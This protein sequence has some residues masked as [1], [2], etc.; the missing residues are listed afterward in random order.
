MW[1]LWFSVST[2]WHLKYS[3]ACLETQPKVR[4][5]LDLQLPNKS[6]LAHPLG[7]SMWLTMRGRVQ[8]P[9]AW[10]PSAGPSSVRLAHPSR[11]LRILASQTG[12]SGLRFALCPLWTN[13]T[14]E[15]CVCTDVCVC[16]SPHLA[17]FHGLSQHDY[18]VNLLVPHHLPEVIDSP[19]NR[20]C[21]GQDI[22]INTSCSMLAYSL[23][24]RK[25]MRSFLGSIITRPKHSNRTSD[26]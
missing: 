5:P 23:C 3:W 15:E 22:E 26:T 4:K 25:Q 2:K 13:G 8:P 6:C 12:H 9:A 7:L 10:Y 11:A 1:V 21:T 17:S 24:Y 18:Y 20:S 16:T 19:R 14:K